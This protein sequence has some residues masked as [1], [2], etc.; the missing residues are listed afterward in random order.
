M[1]MDSATFG[2]SP[3]LNLLFN[4]SGHGKGITATNESSINE[5]DDELAS[6]SRL[7]KTADYLTA[8]YL[9]FLREYTISCLS[10]NTYNAG[11][12]LN[13]HNSCLLLSNFWN[14]NVYFTKQNNDPVPGMFVLIWMHFPWWFQI[15]SWNSKMLTFWKTFCTY[16][17]L[18]PA[19]LKC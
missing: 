12:G 8:A 9:C 6:S 1:T 10:F 5:A 3:P 4:F 2:E 17:L 18:T 16:L 13:E 19:A 7:T 11:I 14:V 15:W